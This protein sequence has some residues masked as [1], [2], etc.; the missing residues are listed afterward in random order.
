MMRMRREAEDIAFPNTWNM[1]GR[2]TLV[3]S[4]RVHGL[5]LLSREVRY[6]LMYIG[7]YVSTRGR[8]LLCRY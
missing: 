6:L 3:E 5:A 2:P 7:T 1:G 8:G 4:G